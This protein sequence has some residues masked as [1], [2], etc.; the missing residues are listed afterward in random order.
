M[1]DFSKMAKELK[2][3]YKRIE[4]FYLN[5]TEGGKRIREVIFELDP[6][7]L[8]P[9]YSIALA[10]IERSYNHYNDCNET[11][12]V[13]EGTLGIRLEGGHLIELDKGS[14]YTITAGVVH[15]SEGIGG[16]V[17]VLVISHPGHTNGGHHI[18]D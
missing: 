13:L 8:H 2:D 16:P 5:D 17:Q 18:V 14:I 3:T 9:Q 11:F 1:D 12:F 10:L 4:P 15:Q 7:R 6:E